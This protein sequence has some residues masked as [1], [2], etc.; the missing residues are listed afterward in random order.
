MLLG[1]EVGLGPGDRCVRWGPCSPPKKNE[2]KSS[3]HF[4]VHAL[5]SPNG[6]MDQDANCYGGRP[7]SRPHCVRLGPS[8]PPAKIG[9]SSPHFSAHVCCG[10]TAGW[11]KM[12]LGTEIGHGPGHTALDENPAHPKGAQS[13][14]FWQMS[15]VAKR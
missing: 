4:S 6:W 8:S 3:P 9:H 10:R 12:P 15:I 7:R 2:G 1:T 5:L 13:S 11:S 14:N